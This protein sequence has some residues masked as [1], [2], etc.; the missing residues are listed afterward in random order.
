[1]SYHQFLSAT[2]LSHQ[3]SAQAK[4]P[5]KTVVKARA[6]THVRASDH[7]GGVMAQRLRWLAPL[8]KTKKEAVAFILAIVGGLIWFAAPFPKEFT[9]TD[10]LREQGYLETVPPAEYYLPG[11][12]NTLEVGTDGRITLHPTCKI[13]AELLSKITLQS[14]TVDHRLAEKLDK[15]FGVTDKIEDFLPIEIRGTKVRSVDLS[16]RNS[17]VLEITD[18][19]LIQIQREVVTGACQEAIEINI[20]SGA[21]VCQTQSALRGDLVYDISFEKNGSAH[22]KDRDSGFQLEPKQGNTDQVV[23]KGLIYGV[24]FV[25][26]GI[27]L[28]TPDAKPADCR[29]PS[30]NKT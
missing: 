21:I 10:L 8:V 6:S 9:L 13:H 7:D 24:S 2:N 30:K 20:N 26:H 11:T 14:R 4:R 19:E 5:S 23:G 22:V 25:S 29:F 1:M 3:P 16:L 12:I 28:N 18:E 17:N 15:K 27:V